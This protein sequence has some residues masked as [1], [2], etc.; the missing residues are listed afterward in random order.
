MTQE[1]LLG[2]WELV[3]CE[4]RSADGGSFLPYGRSPVGKLIYTA[5]GHL[6]V[7]LMNSERSP[8]RS[9]DISQ[10]STDEIVSAF[11]SFDAYTGRWSLNHPSGRLEH[12][13]E[14]G[15]IP[16][17]VQKTHIRFCQLENGELTL[18]TEEFSMGDQ[19]WR[20]YVGW[21]RP[22]S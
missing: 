11:N 18:S 9:E 22:Q 1:E 21:K 20:V 13:I 6:A 15:R 19:S 16:N 5:D 7:V 2:V 14:A 17:W 4:G 10:A 8:F 3:Y 12:H